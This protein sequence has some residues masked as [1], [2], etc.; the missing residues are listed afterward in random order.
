[1]KGTIKQP[2]KT[3]IASVKSAIFLGLSAA[4]FAAAGAWFQATDDSAT[5]ACACSSDTSYNNNLPASH[6]NNRCATQARDLTWGSW[7]TGSSRSGQFHFVDL[8]ELLNG[9]QDKPMDKT[10]SSA[11]DEL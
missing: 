4:F 10:P 8:L 9:H 5:V 1:M 3:A 7:L 2:G 11:R 6:P